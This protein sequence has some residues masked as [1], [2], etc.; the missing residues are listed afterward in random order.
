[1]VIGLERFR[2][3]FSSFTEQYVLIGGTA[4]AVIMQNSGL[5][6]RSTKDLDIVLYVEAL[7]TDFVTAF[8]QFIKAGGYSNQ[9]RST[10]KEIFY[11]FTSPTAV[12]FPF[13]LELFSRKPDTVKL[14]GQS[15]LTP[16]P[17]HETITSLSAILLDEHYYQFIR[18]GKKELDGLPVLDASYLIPLKARACIDLEDRK[19]NGMVVDE[20]DI[21]KHQN[22]IIRLYQLLSSH[23]RVKLPESIKEDMSLFLRHLKE[24]G[25]IDC[26][27]FGLK[28]TNVDQIIEM[29]RKIY[30]ITQGC[31]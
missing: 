11:R 4:C 16:I 20:K 24:D 3:H 26:K 6:F 18:S 9:Q 12:D 19:N 23:N 14:T 5:A 30:G 15:H 29:L 13:M 28:H 10:G 25:S 2:R 21:R 1:M 27:N 17:M 22:D 31:R 8:W 7:N